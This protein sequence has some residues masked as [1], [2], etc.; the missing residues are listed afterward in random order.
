M[1]WIWHKHSYL[2]VLVTPG[3]KPG[4]P[5]L[6]TCV[7][8]VAPFQSCSSSVFSL[9]LT[10]QKYLQALWGILMPTDNKYSVV[11][12]VGVCGLFPEAYIDRILHPSIIFRW[13]SKGLYTGDT[14]WGWYEWRQTTPS[15]LPA[16]KPLNSSPDHRAL[17]LYLAASCLLSVVFK[18]PK[19][20]TSDQ[21][22]LS[23]MRT[24]SYLQ[25]QL[26]TEVVD[27]TE[28]SCLGE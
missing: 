5:Y 16:I 28:L 3:N 20:R 26:E 13:M 19:I 22:L 14:N 1:F 8:M 9:F 27:Y 21:W 7:H 10:W 4:F 25:L 12:P 11:V 18:H 6:P 24:G 15:I 23:R 17:R 2:S